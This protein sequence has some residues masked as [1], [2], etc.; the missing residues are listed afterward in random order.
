[1]PRASSGTSG[2]F[3]CGMIELPVQ[4]RSAMS[5]KPKLWLIHN[6]SSSLRRLT[7]TMQQAKAAAVN[8]MAKS[9]SLTAVQ[10]VLADA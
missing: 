10:A 8:S 7:C 3:F 5:M 4:N 6:T 9:R 2:F 1:L